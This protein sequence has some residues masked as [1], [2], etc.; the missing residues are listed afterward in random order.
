ML[1]AALDFLTTFR[2]TRAM[3]HLFARACGSSVGLTQSVTGMKDW[4]GTIE[5]QTIGLTP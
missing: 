2:F 4:L 5:G 1:T 3:R